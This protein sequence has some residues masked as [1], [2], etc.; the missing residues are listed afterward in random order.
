MKTLDEIGLQY[1][2]D[3]SSNFHNYL[4]LYEKY[5][6]EIR[7]KENIILEIGILYGDSLKIFSDYLKFLK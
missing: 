5:F 3:K 1:N 7:F 6:S 2:S 4:N